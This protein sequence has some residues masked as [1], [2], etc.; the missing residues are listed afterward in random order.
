MQCTTKRRL[1][2]LVLVRWHIL[3]VL[4]LLVLVLGG[5]VPARIGRLRH[6]PDAYGRA[7]RRLQLR[8]AARSGSG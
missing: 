1:V 3:V 7:L 6:Q 4:S 8:L 2:Q 5:Q